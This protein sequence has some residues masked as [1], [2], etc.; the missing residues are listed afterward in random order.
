MPEPAT[1]SSDRDATAALARALVRR[2]RSASL[3]T[4]LVEGSSGGPPPYASLVTVA[5]DVDGRPAFL[6]SGL[7]DHT[8]NLAAD[9]RAAVLIEEASRRRNPQTGPRLTLTGTIGN[10]D[11]PRIR[12]RFLAR[13]PDAA[14]YAGFKDFGFYRMAVERGHFVGGFA[15]AR[16]LGGDD[17]TIRDQALVEA[18]AAMEVGVLQHMNTDHPDA[19]NLYANVLLK[20]GGSGWTAIGLDPEGLDLRR[21]SAFARLDFPAPIGDAAGC[22]ET[23]VRL[24]ESARRGATK[25]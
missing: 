20:R 12:R 17:L 7:A 14:L 24:A 11:E 16:W 4:L 8:K 9:S 21:G 5:T 18:V 1:Q 25:S 2:A 15:R 19:L 6:F 10:T 23:L 3:A 22:R 13:H